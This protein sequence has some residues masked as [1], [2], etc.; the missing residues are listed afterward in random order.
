M[1]FFFFRFPNNNVEGQFPHISKLY[2][3]IIKSVEDSRVYCGL[4][5]TNGMRILLISDQTTDKSAAAL[6]VR[7][8]KFLKIIYVCM[9]IEI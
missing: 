3:E 6:N 7:V 5:L 2:K 8:G 1:Y 4:E 9:F